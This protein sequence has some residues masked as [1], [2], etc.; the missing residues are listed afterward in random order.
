M[1]HIFKVNLRNSTMTKKTHKNDSHYNPSF[2]SEL[3]KL[4][5]STMPSKSW[6]QILIFFPPQ[7]KPKYCFLKHKGLTILDKKEKLVI[8][9]PANLW[10]VNS[11]QKIRTVLPMNPKWSKSH[12]T[13]RI[14]VFMNVFYICIY[15]FFWYL[16]ADDGK[17]GVI[18]LRIDI[19]QRS[20][21]RV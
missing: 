7:V 9:W 5:L 11:V 21:R 2:T 15:G 1:C 6:G 20:F 3:E 14:Y 16:F 8:G 4:P 17:H 12:F 18:T 19:K 10:P 13:K